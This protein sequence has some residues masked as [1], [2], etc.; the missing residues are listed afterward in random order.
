M[1]VSTSAARVLILILI[2]SGGAAIPLAA[3][4]PSKVAAAGAAYIPDP[5]PEEDILEGKPV[6]EIHSLHSDTD[7]KYMVGLWRCSPGTFRWTC[8]RDEFVYFLEGEAVVS[9]KD[10]PTLTIQ[11]GEAAYFPPGETTWKIVT[12]VTKTYSLRER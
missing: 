7:G 5:I 11:A 2:L 10:G 12:P 8:T 9:Y 6:A 4:E 3:A 1:K